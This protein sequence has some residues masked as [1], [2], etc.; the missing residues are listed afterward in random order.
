MD[1][2]AEREVRAGMRNAAV[3]RRLP[4]AR[5]QGQERLSSF[6]IEQRGGN[7]SALWRGGQGQYLAELRRRPPGPDPLRRG[8]QPC[9]TGKF[10]PGSRIPI[11]DEERLRSDNPTTS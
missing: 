7:Q 6:L 9:Q 3:L 4:G 8:P 5:R 2:A 10:L 11:V 1:R